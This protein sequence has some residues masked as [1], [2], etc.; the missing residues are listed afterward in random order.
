VLSYP[1][2]NENANLLRIKNLKRIFPEFVIGY[3]DH[4]LPDETMT[5]LTTAFLFGAE[6]IEKHFTLD[7]KLQGNDHYHAM[8]PEDLAKFQRNIETLNQV[9]EKDE[10]NYLKCE[11]VPR[12][13]ARRSLVLT[14]DVAIGEQITSDKLTMKRPG[15]GI[16]PEFYEL[17][18]NKK[19]NKALE[20]DHILQFEDFMN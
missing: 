1:T 16:S 3:S 9:L 17:I 8:D 7:K 15:T 20:E 18:L 2:K 6:I 19:V 5:I 14:Q 4:T 10:V 13:Q 12:K 11:N